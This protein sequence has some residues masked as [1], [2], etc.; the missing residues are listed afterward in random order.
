LWL[1]HGP[2]GLKVDFYIPIRT[3]TASN[4]GKYVDGATGTLFCWWECKM[5]Q[6]FWKMLWQFLTTLKILLPFNPATALLGN[7]PK[8]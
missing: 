4:V 7:Y 6:S 8:V 2:H 3:L 1:A 5:V